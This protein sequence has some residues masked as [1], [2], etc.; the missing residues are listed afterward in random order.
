MLLEICGYKSLAFFGYGPRVGGVKVRVL[1][2]RKRWVFLGDGF[3]IDGDGLDGFGRRVG[4][5][6]GSGGAEE[7]EGLDGTRT[8][9]V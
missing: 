2:E 7:S 4:V 1:W 8:G 6:R 9:G 5:G 3:R